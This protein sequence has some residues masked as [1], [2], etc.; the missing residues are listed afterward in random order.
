MPGFMTGLQSGASGGLSD[1]I[2]KFKSKMKGKP[3]GGGKDGGGASDSGSGVPGFY[4]SDLTSYHKG[5]TV[6]KTGPAMLK[7]GERVLTKS[8]QKRVM[9]KRRS[10]K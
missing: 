10:G 6:R 5:G 4:G 2:G 3:G 1:I 8:Q 7:R 9:G